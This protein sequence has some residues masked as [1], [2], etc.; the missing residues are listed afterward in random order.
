MASDGYSCRQKIYGKVCKMSYEINYIKEINKQLNSLDFKNFF[1][2]E[3][4]IK[5]FKNNKNK[6]IYIFGNG[7]SSAIS[8]HVVTDFLKNNKI[9]FLNF[10][11][12]SLIT[13]FA[14][15]YGY[16]NAISNIL[17]NYANKDDLVILISSSGNSRNIRNA[18]RYCKT[19]KIKIIGF[20]G[21]KKNNYLNK[22]SDI[23]FWVNSKNY[24]IVENTHQIWLLMLC[25]KLAKKKII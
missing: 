8:S 5:K 20:S 6:K 24:N 4:I 14:N 7:G 12:H 25:D 1:K 23:N 16:E 17:K 11:D 2:A 9:N 18:V 22:N 15:D 21:F 10:T 19:K 3:K 13:C